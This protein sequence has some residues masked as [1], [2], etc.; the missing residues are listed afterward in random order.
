VVRDRGDSEYT[1]LNAPDD[2]LVIAAGGPA[3]GFRAVMTL[4][5]GS[6]GLGAWA[7]YRRGRPRLR[8]RDLALAGQ[9]CTAPKPP[10]AV[11]RAEQSQMGG[12]YPH[13]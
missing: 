4:L 6:A 11:K 2:L 7:G 12:R 8:E 3:G 10:R 9:G 1:A 13:P 5:H